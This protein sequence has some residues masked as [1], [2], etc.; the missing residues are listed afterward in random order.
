MKKPPLNKP[1]TQRPPIPAVQAI[2]WSSDMVLAQLQ[3]EFL[4]ELLTGGPDWDK[5][6][7][8]H[9]RMAELDRFHD[10]MERQL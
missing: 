1:N 9:E 8:L 4:R 10:A 6:L 2:V 5:L 3:L 7:D